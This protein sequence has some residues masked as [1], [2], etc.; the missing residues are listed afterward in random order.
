MKDRLTGF[1]NYQQIL[2][3]MQ[4]PNPFCF[5][6]RPLNKG[7]K[8]IIESALKFLLFVWI[9]TNEHTL[10]TVLVRKLLTNFLSIIDNVLD[11]IHNLLDRKR[12]LLYWIKQC[13]IRAYFLWKDTEHPIFG[14]NWTFHLRSRFLYNPLFKPK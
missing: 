6:S 1:L 5:S 9:S 12:L 3:Q 8:K 11:F 7:N 2:F 14:F 10:E 4:R 13:Y